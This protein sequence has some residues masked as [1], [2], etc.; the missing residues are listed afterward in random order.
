M[1]K[2][3]V[4]I[5]TLAISGAAFAAPAKATVS[6]MNGTIEKSDGATR[7]L[8]VTHDG[9][10]QTNFQIGDKAEVMKGKSKADASSLSTSAGQAV[11][12]AYVMEGTSRVAEK[13]E[14]AAAAAHSAA[15]KTHK[16]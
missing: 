16:K 12:V 1:K 11:K 15:A 2:L 13:I 8:T 9:N 14:V 4:L 7:T 5:C 3:L 6:H 10:K